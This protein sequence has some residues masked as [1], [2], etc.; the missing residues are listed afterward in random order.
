MMNKIYTIGRGSG[1]DIKTP[2]EHNAVGKLHLR[3]E[4]TGGDQARVTDL[5][6]TNGT[7]VRVG[8]EWE[9]IKGT[10]LVQLDEELMLGDYKI[11]PRRLLAEVAPKKYRSS[12]EE[13]DAPPPAPPAKKRT[14]P[15]RNAFGE[16]VQE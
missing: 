11:T 16:I 8:A 12:K 5:Q 14:G 2:K 3:L 15:R 9:E 6:S 1:A 10:R 4:D 13:E 7:F